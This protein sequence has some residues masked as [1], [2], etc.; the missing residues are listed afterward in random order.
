MTDINSSHDRFG[1]IADK[2]FGDRAIGQRLDSVV[3]EISKYAR[4]SKKLGAPAERKKKIGQAGAAAIK[5]LRHLDNIDAT[6]RRLLFGGGE[7]PTH[8]E[9][10]RTSLQAAGPAL[11]ADALSKLIEFEA[12]LKE[13]ATNAGKLVTSTPPQRAGAHELPDAIRW[14]VECLIAFW[15]RYR[16]DTPT[17]GQNSN[18]FG[19]FVEAVLCA[20]PVDASRANVRTALRYYFQEQADE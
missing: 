2:W 15:K 13:M 5:L 19:N 8:P 10:T 12:L 20:E 17:S 9:G 18:S 3:T 4:D 16:D 6:T 14:G 7:I 11:N 1:T